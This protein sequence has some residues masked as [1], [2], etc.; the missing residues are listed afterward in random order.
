MLDKINRM[1]TDT[2]DS[3]LGFS[4]PFAAFAYDQTPFDPSSLPTDFQHK[5]NNLE[6]V[7]S[8]I[9]ESML[10]GVGTKINPGTALA[11]HRTVHKLSCD[12]SNEYIVG[13]EPSMLKYAYDRYEFLVANTA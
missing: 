8:N 3:L 5:W 12:K 9:M 10:Q 11:I 7:I 6:N 1:S 4:P 2:D 13:R